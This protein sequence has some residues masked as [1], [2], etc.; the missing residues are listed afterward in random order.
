MG[1]EIFSDR[2]K[3]TQTSHDIY[4]FLEEAMTNKTE[5]GRVFACTFSRPRT[6][7]LYLDTLEPF[8]LGYDGMEAKTYL[9]SM[10]HKIFWKKYD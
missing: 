8:I 5:D 2:T 1:T 9:V 7:N 3:C 10:Q 4:R 6:S